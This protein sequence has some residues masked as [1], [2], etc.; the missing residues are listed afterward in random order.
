MDGMN[1]KYFFLTNDDYITPF[2]IQNAHFPEENGAV[3]S[4]NGPVTLRI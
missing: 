2:I 1:I 4:E 3:M